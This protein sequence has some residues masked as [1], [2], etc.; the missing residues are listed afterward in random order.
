MS[1]SFRRT[2]I[3]GNTTCRSERRDKQAWHGRWRARE[4]DAIHRSMK[5][6]LETHLP[7][8]ER[9]AS[10]TWSMGKDG[11]HYWSKVAQEKV[12]DRMAL[13]KSFKLPEQELA[14]L[15]TRNLRK[16]AAK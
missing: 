15:R 4:R 7:V 5:G 2:P 11:R 8:L 13:H 3:F 9:E 6:D 1:R 12:A 16:W 14:A 10:N